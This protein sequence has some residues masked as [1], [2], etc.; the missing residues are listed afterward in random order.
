MVKQY[1][2]DEIVTE[3]DILINSKANK[4][5]DIKDK[6]LLHNFLKESSLYLHALHKEIINPE[7]FKKHLDIIKGLSISEL[8]L[9][10]DYLYFFGKKENYPII[11]KIINKG[12]ILDDF[13]RKAHKVSI[14]CYGS[15]KPDKDSEK[16]SY[17]DMIIH[18]I[19]YISAIGD[20]ETRELAQNSISNI[21]SKVL[22][23]IIKL[24]QATDKG[25]RTTLQLKAYHQ[26]LYY[27]NVIGIKKYGIFPQ[28]DREY[29][30]LIKTYENNK[31]DLKEI[32]RYMN[33]INGLS[34]EDMFMI[35]YWSDLLKL[36]KSRDIVKKVLKDET[37]G[38][39]D[40]PKKTYDIIIE[41]HEN[42]KQNFNTNMSFKQ[43]LM[44]SVRHMYNNNKYKRLK[45]KIE[46]LL[47]YVDK[48]ILIIPK[49]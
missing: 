17:R 47:E 41:K 12:I 2:L 30:T 37:D 18:F 10:N 11:D 25:L 21:K 45:Q 26:E 31:I 3:Y 39:K 7:T 49:K 48:D 42:L 9:I 43:T 32:E 46:P 1:S 35:G 6:N 13:E 28:L 8:K 38:L 16:K 27:L 19:R 15:Y 20:E 24:Y 5:C 14:E 40:E 29:H 4:I 33:I 44:H 23:P 34:M 36:D 22:D